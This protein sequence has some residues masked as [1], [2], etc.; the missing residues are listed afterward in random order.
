MA[1]S[2]A[3]YMKEWRAKNIELVREHNRRYYEKNKDKVLKEQAKWR[4]E[5]PRRNTNKRREYS[6][7]YYKD[8]NDYF[9]QYAQTHK[10]HVNSKQRERYKAG[11][12]KR[13]EQYERKRQY[14]DSIKIHYGCQNPDCKWSGDYHPRCL[15]FHHTAPSTKQ[16]C[17]ATDGRAKNKLIAEIRKTT[18]LCSNCHRLV[19]AG[20][21]DAR[22]FSKCKLDDNGNIIP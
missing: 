22:G 1:K 16:K 7:Q 6:K 2:R 3:E 8:H 17:I 5:H 4:K 14:T 19:T 12:D 13:T 20:V 21:L 11:N 18:V 10:E 15:D 9:S